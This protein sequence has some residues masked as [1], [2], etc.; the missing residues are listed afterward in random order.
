MGAGRQRPRVAAAVLAGLLL[1]ACDGWLVLSA[2]E[3]AA[4]WAWVALD[5]EADRVTRATALRP[6][7][8]PLELELPL[9]ERAFLLAYGAEAT[10][11]LG[12]LVLTPERLREAE[13]CA[14]RLPPPERLYAL[15]GDELEPVPSAPVPPLTASW[16]GSRC[17]GAG[18]DE[19]LVDVQCVSDPC[20]ATAHR[21]GCGVRVEGP[22]CGLEAFELGVDPH[23]PVCAES[24]PC[25]VQS[26]VVDAL[27]ALSCR[28]PTFDEPCS[29]R[30]FRPEP[31]PEVELERVQVVDEPPVYFEEARYAPYAIRSGHL[32]DLVL[33]DELVLVTSLVGSNGGAGA[34]RH[35]AVGQRVHVYDRASLAP[36]A[37]IPL[38]RCAWGLHQ[39]RPGEFM[40]FTVDGPTEQVLA[41]SFSLAEGTVR[42][43][44]IAAVGFDSSFVASALRLEDDRSVVLVT[45][46][47]L[48]RGLLLFVDHQGRGLSSVSVNNAEFSGLTAYRDGFVV[49]ESWNDSFMYF[50]AE[51]RVLATVPVPE[52]A[53]RSLGDPH[54]HRPSGS[55]AVPIARDV[56]QV[57]VMGSGFELLPRRLLHY[58]RA[59]APTALAD[60]PP[61]PRL[62]VAGVVVQGPAPV[63]FLARLD[64][65][66]GHYLPGVVEVGPGA[67]S[68]MRTDPEGRVYVLLS[69]TGLLVR[70]TPR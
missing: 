28:R 55:V 60:W 57:A 35:H 64:P 58:E 46:P 26:E 43:A 7:S 59:A 1:W 2:P 50:D 3:G 47:L 56:R 22:A 30:V 49:T 52:R 65:V 40:G 6:V 67:A 42:T 10:S 70:L 38:P 61:D 8:E 44:T 21:T 62:L 51:G 37:E 24:G 11:S 66:A 25:S 20:S 5:A 23:A 31:F 29:I 33:T 48:G 14:P 69:W 39:T 45:S 68:V 12:A 53:S 18:L 41:L 54:L 32:G 36:R 34:C 9:G 17:V 16:L 19:L 27:V 63:T 4:L 13:G 15:R